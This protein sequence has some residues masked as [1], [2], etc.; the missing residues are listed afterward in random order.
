MEN[1]KPNCQ[2]ILA[3]LVRMHLIGFNWM[4]ELAP[5]C[6]IKSVDLCTATLDMQNCIVLQKCPHN[7]HGIQIIFYLLM[8]FI[9]SSKPP[10]TNFESRSIMDVVVVAWW[11]PNSL[12]TTKSEEFKVDNQLNLP[13]S[14]RQWY[15]KLVLLEFIAVE[16]GT[17]IFHFL[18]TLVALH[19]THVSQSV[20]RSFD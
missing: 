5:I 4:P 16:Q 10:S 12:K 17:S 19:F 2:K 7:L 1:L 9:L 13:F 15:E 8:L 6:H 3:E 20:S 14:E 11:R 18:A